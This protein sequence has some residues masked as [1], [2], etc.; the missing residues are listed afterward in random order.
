M[1][2]FS[3]GELFIVA[4]IGLA[5]VGKRDL[6]KAAHA[7]GTQVGRIVGFLQGARA[8]ADRFTA[9]SQLQ[10]LQNEL[11][12]GLRELDAVKSE[13]AVSMSPSNMV[14]R[15]LGAL[16]A[17][18]SIGGTPY[19][20]GGTTR[21][22]LPAAG[23]GSGGESTPLSI[24]QSSWPSTTSLTT[25][26]TYEQQEQ[27]EISNTMLPQTSSF[28]TDYQTTAAVAEA[29]WA[30]QGIGYSSSA[31]AQTHGGSGQLASLLQQSLIFD[32][33]D[34]VVAQQDSILQS[35]VEAIRQKVDAS[36][37]TNTRDNR[38]SS[39]TASSANST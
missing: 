38:G 33:Y 10:Q 28:S 4:G 24:A 30:K 14:G 12:S 36:K 23:L 35:K 32:R 11:R 16:T 21:R 2:D 26:P 25:S 8:R 17:N 18:A 22:L 9:N 29:E 15:N 37:K 31:E 1:L 5:F 6:P 7:V 27:L 19:G 3:W 13:L 39:D 34:R 20:V